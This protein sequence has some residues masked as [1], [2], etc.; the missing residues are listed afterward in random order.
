MAE[1]KYETIRCEIAEGLATITLDR[2]DVLNAMNDGMRRELTR[3][4]ADL[5]GDD[6][7]RLP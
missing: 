5:S 3:C 7:V 4:F 1:A 2:P 6:D